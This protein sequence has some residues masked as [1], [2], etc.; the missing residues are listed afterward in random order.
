MFCS[1]LVCRASLCSSFLRSALLITSFLCCVL[2]SSF[3]R[4]GV[5]LSSSLLGYS[6][7]YFLLFCFILFGLHASS[8]QGHFCFY[9][10]VSSRRCEVPETSSKSNNERCP[11]EVIHVGF[12]EHDKSS[13]RAGFFFLF[14]FFFLERY[15]FISSREFY[16]ADVYASA[17]D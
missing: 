7:L 17:L 2:L 12:P 8:A 15:S 14:F 5:Q 10:D 11:F 13:S 6:L 1:N 4:C 9:T 3:L 16:S